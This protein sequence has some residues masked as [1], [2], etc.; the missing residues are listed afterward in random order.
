M[1][2]AEVGD[3]KEAS[4]END[5]HIKQDLDLRCGLFTNST[6]FIVYL[7]F[8]LTFQWNCCRKVSRK[9]SRVDIQKT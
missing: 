4:D 1:W 6:Y 7:G 9:E 5:I 3:K 8:S 2:V